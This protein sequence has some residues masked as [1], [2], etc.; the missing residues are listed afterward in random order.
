MNVKFEGNDSDQV[1]KVVADGYIN[2]NSKKES[3]T[4]KTFTCGYETAKVVGPNGEVY[5]VALTVSRDK[6]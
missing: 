6:N 4:K 1:W 2:P 5:R 3:G